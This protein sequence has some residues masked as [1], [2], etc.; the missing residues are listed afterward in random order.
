LGYVVVGEEPDDS[1]RGSFWGEPYEEWARARVA[2][3]KQEKN[4]LVRKGGHDSRGDHAES[5]DE[6]K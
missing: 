4:G 6:D 5:D 2:V 1:H 3:S